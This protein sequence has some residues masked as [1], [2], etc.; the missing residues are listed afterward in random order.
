M[1]INWQQIIKSSLGLKL[2]ILVYREY[3]FAMVSGLPFRV[4]DG[5]CLV[6]LCD[7]SQSVFAILSKR[8]DSRVVYTALCLGN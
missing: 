2:W 7:A 8:G 3:R 6:W 4:V 5:D 1:N